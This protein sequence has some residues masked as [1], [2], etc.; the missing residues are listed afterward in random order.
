MKKNRMSKSRD[1]AWRA[2]EEALAAAQLMP[3]GT[4]R[5]AALKEAGQLRFQ[6]D[7]RLRARRA[8]MD[9]LKAQKER[10]DSDEAR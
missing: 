10:K 5:A 7:E 9:F 2:A 6:A 8:R 1:K 4:A 3:R